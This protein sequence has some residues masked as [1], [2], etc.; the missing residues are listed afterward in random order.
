MSDQATTPSH[1]THI[2]STSCLE[3]GSL[4]KTMELSRSTDFISIQNLYL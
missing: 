4:K 3:N 1:E 2:N